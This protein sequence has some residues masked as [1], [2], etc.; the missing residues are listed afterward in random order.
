MTIDEEKEV[1]AFEKKH[2][3]TIIEMSNNEFQEAVK[4][5]S[6]EV[7]TAIINRLRSEKKFQEK[8]LE[9]PYVKKNP[10]SFRYAEAI[11]IIPI[12]NTKGKLLKSIIDNSNK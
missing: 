11:R 6:S 9:E 3:T 12:I 4:K 10:N 8:I 7:L 2:K 5:E 1:K